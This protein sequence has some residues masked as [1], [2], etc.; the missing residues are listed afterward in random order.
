[1][2]ASHGYVRILPD[3]TGKRLTH[4][5]SMEVPYGNGTLAFSIGDIVTAPVSGITG[6]VVQVVGTATSGILHIHLDVDGYQVPNNPEFTLNETIQVN[7]ITHAL[8]S[9]PSTAYYTQ[10]SSLVSSHNSHNGIHIDGK[11][12]MFTRF[13][14]GSPQFDA[15]GKMQVSQ[16]HIVAEYYHQ[17]GIDADKVSQNFVGSGAMVHI[18]ES[19][20][21]KLTVG[22]DAGAISEMVSHQYHPYRLGQSRLIEFTLQCGDAGKD[23]LQRIWGY[24]DDSDGVFFMQYNGIWYTRIKSTSGNGVPADTLIPQSDWNGDRMDGSGGVF[25]PSG[26]NMDLTKDNITWIDLQW[27]G[28]GT[29]RSGVVFNG[30]RIVCHEWHNS[31]KHNAPYM[32]TGSLPIYY[33]LKN[34]IATASASEMKVWCTVVKTEGDIEFP[35]KDFGYTPP[36]VSLTTDAEVPLLSFRSKEL[37]NGL[38]N[39][40]S[41]Y[42]SDLIFLTTA[43]PITIRLVKNGVLTGAT[44][45]VVPELG[46]C[47]EFDTT[48]TA[49]SNGVDK[50]NWL[51]G[52]G[53]PV[54]MTVDDVFNP[55]DDGIRRHFNPA[56]FDTYTIV[57][58]RLT[59]VATNVHL[60]LNWDDV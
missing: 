28:A 37:L 54:E 45:G 46:G 25:N 55:Q 2:A 40:K 35:S 18:P 50:H 1:M 5:V 41:S 33:E 21:V 39:R 36:V 20:G 42:L 38:T 17:Y 48:A 4:T 11:G 32:R 60:S 56:E 27:L 43:T 15:F 3:S 52:T 47:L 6:T 8:V 19:G 14:E 57:V 9:E 24:G 31:N 22:T 30:K 34:Q 12:A 59:P 58:K 44:W 7:A 13:T 53:T 29:V 10:L 16:Q 49:I 26:Y 23:G 51:A